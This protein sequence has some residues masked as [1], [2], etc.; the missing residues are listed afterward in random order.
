MKYSDYEIWLPAWDWILA[1]LPSFMYEKIQ[2]GVTREQWRHPFG[3]A[4]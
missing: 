4:L 3:Y 1:L 2:I